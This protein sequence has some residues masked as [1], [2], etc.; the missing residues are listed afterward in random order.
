MTKTEIVFTEEKNGY[1]KDE[2]DNYVEK[3][4]EA[5]QK[6]Y[7]EYQTVCD[8]YK[9]LYDTYN[10]LLEESKM[11]NVPRQTGL[12]SEI[13]AKTLMDTEIL[14]QKI[15][16]N[17]QALAAVC[18][19]NGLEVLT[20]GTDNHLMLINVHKAGLT[21]R[22]AES[23]M[24]EYNMTVNRNS[25]PKDPN[26]PWYTSG[27]RIGTA[28]IT[29]LGMG[30]AEMAEIGSIITDAI[31]GTTQVSDT[32]DPSK[33]S[34]AKYVIAEKAKT[35]ALD[36]VKKLMDRFPVYPELDLNFLKEAFALN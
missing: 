19:K 2:V 26:G 28:A 6:A 32:K 10:S 27:M 7:G 11:T 34:K 31:K 24:T 5:Y 1:A 30:E 25:I 21:G 8:N 35:E 14:A 15:I 18:M 13:I 9:K 20:G 12:N 4:S 16:D 22:Q 17:C 33:M 36:R 29:S 3:I 23:A